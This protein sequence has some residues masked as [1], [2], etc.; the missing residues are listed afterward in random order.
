MNW[1]NPNT[2][3]RPFTGGG[4]G[5]TGASQAGAA[6][7]TNGFTQAAA[8]IG[9]AVSQA[10]AGITQA[11]GQATAGLAQAVTGITGQGQK[12]GPGAPG[13]PGNVPVS[14]ESAAAGWGPM[15]GDS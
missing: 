9:Q 1:M 2:W 12:P 6:P 8:G 14:N 5:Q 10:T 11:V 3:M 4:Q 7:A 13:A 15:P